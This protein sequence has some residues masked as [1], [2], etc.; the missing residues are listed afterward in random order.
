MLSK[1]AIRQGFGGGG[2]D[3]CSEIEIGKTVTVGIS[4]EMVVPDV[5]L[6]QVIK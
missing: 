4:R 3:I 2:C 6:L 1:H 5:D